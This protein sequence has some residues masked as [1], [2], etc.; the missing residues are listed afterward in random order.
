MLRA[1]SSRV[2]LSGVLLVVVASGL[3][4]AET[5]NINPHKIVLNARGAS[6][7][8]QANIHIILS[9]APVIDFD[10]TLT[11]KGSVVAEV[12]AESAFYCVLDNILIVGFDRTELQNNPEVQALANQTVTATVTGAVLMADGTWTDFDGSDTVEI[13]APGKKGQ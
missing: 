7:D 3:C 8:V 9:G 11:L 4:W 6:D 5:V 1:T 12:K 10:V 13:V 2:L